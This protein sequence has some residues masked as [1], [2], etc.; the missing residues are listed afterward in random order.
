MDV[1]QHVAEGASAKDP[2]RVVR[3]ADTPCFHAVVS[4]KREERS[5]SKAIDFAHQ[6]APP[7][8]V[9]TQYSSVLDGLAIPQHP[10]GPSAD[11][12][13]YLDSLGSDAVK[14]SETFP[15]V[16]IRKVDMKAFNDQINARDGQNAA[17]WRQLCFYRI[18]P[19]KTTPQSDDSV[20]LPDAETDALN[21]DACAHIYA[22]DRNSLFLIQRA[23]GFEK[24]QASAGSLAHT[25]IFHGSPRNLPTIGKDGEP[26]WWVQE[27]WTS[28]SGES[29][30]CH[31]SR[32]WDY[33]EGKIIATTVQDGMMRVPTADH[34]VYSKE[35][36]PKR[37]RKL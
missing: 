30:G 34:S 19:Y 6:D 2:W 18:I 32:L 24:R 29:R 31:E 36:S 14:H 11:A 21:L 37:E 25:V 35:S 17:G 1:Y 7:D 26:K 13:W 23:L 5:S 22:S 10:R 28:N 16:E 20:V 12:Q 33:D 4:F 27:A 3:D 9:K 15:G 8:H